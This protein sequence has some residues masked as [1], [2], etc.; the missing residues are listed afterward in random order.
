[1]LPGPSKNLTRQ[2]RDATR[3]APCVADA[4]PSRRLE[5]SQ[6]GREDGRS[7]RFFYFEPRSVARRLRSRRSTSDVSNQSWQLAVGSL[8]LREQVSAR[9]ARNCQLPTPNC[10]LAPPSRPP[11]RVSQGL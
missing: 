5:I 6:G 10:Q 7:A 2:S 4:G 1:M 11:C 9:R 8:E 3:C